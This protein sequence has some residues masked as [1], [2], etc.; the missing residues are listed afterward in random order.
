MARLKFFL[1]ALLI[2]GAWAAHLYLLTPKLSARAVE[3]AEERASAAPA[4]VLA[5]LQQRRLDLQ[6]AALKVAGTPEA[7]A[8]LMPTKPGKVE[9]PTAE[10]LAAVK[11]VLNDSV[12][13]ALKKSLVVA[14]SNEAG[15]IAA[16]GDDA[17]TDGT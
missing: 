3:Q 9:A 16:R 15:T 1:F 2:L 11:A 14:L 4:S 10:K 8:V 7:M 13:P 17:A 5:Q 6:R 12:T